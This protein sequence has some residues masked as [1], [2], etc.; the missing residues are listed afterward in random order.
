[1]NRNELLSE[2]LMEYDEDPTLVPA[3][4]T[5]FI[6]YLVWTGISIGVVFFHLPYLYPLPFVIGTLMLS[7][8]IILVIACRDFP[9]PTNIKILSVYGYVR[10]YLSL[11]Y[12]ILGLGS[13]ITALVLVVADYDKYHNHTSHEADEI[14]DLIYAGFMYGLMSMVQGLLMLAFKN[15]YQEA[16]K[17]LQLKYRYGV[18]VARSFVVDSER[19]SEGP[20]AKKDSPQDEEIA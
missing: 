16:V 7:S 10:F 6:I 9:T 2:N 8:F 12:V 1:M 17:F 11:L 18:K 13:I 5:D 14:K 15:S 20:T 3:C 19:S 4:L